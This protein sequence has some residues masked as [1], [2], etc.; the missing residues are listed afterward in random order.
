VATDGCIVF[1]KH[2]R[3]CCVRNVSTAFL[4]MGAGR[5]LFR[6]WISDHTWDELVLPFIDSTKDPEITVLSPIEHIHTRGR[7]P[8]E[9]STSSLGSPAQKAGLVHLP[10]KVA[11]PVPVSTRQGCQH[12]TPFG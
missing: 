12:P 4:A 8:G 11:S 9:P 1:D 2:I 7:Q 3:L 10:E 6:E 5:F